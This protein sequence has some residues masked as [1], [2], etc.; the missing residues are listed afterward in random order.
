MWRDGGLDTHL[1]LNLRLK[2]PNTINN[3]V[4]AFLFCGIALKIQLE[5]G[6]VR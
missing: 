4:L 6:T 1:D 2:M 3:V 5:K